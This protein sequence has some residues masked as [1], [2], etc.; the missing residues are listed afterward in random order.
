MTLG[1]HTREPFI[2]CF[3]GHFA[4]ALKPVN[5]RWEGGL[6]RTRL[7]HSAVGL[8][9]IYQNLVNFGLVG[10]NFSKSTSI[11]PPLI[12]SI[13]KSGKIGIGMALSRPTLGINWSRDGGAG[14]LVAN[15]EDGGSMQ[16]RAGVGERTWRGGRGGDE[17]W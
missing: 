9:G 4:S 2:P 8:T 10:P 11:L 6:F 1:I 14:S 13:A 17:D 5:G 7:C 12:F 16:D 3:G 15:L